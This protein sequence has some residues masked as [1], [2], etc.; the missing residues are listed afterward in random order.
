MCKQVSLYL[1]LLWSFHIFQINLL[2]V[3]FWLYL[4]LYVCLSLCLS[5]SLS[6][7]LSVSLFISYFLSFFLR[8][9]IDIFSFFLSCLF[10]YL[11]CLHFSLFLAF[12]LCLKH[13]LDFCF[14]SLTHP[15]MQLKDNSVWERSVKKRKKKQ[16]F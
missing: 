7:S 15:K 10:F 6:L 16:K 4:C 9:Y 2:T 3:S 11:S 5:V 13:C 14:C 8:S 1:K 12:F